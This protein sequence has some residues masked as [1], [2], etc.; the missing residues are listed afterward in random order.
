MQ[1]TTTQVLEIVEISR[2][3]LQYWVA[4]GKVHKR[5]G[6][7]SGRLWDS[8]DIKLLLDLKIN[9]APGPKPK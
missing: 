4:S 7:G 9:S 8:S 3:T 1:Y 6:Q 5:G 2:R